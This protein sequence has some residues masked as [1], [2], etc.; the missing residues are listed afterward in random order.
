MQLNFPA[1]LFPREPVFLKCAGDAQKLDNITTPSS[2]RLALSPTNRTQ[3]S[4]TYYTNCDDILSI[5]APFTKQQ[6][7][8][9]RC[10]HIFKL[11]RIPK[12]GSSTMF[13]L[14][15]SLSNGGCQIHRQEG[16]T[17]I[18]ANGIEKYT[19]NLRNPWNRFIS[20]FFYQGHA[21]LFG[22]RSP[23]KIDRILACSQ[24]SFDKRTHTCPT[25]TTGSV[26]I[27]DILE[28]F[29]SN[30]ADTKRQNV[31]SKMWCGQPAYSNERVRCSMYT[32]KRNVCQQLEYAYIVEAPI[33]SLISLQLNF[34]ID[35]V[36]KIQLGIVNSSC[37]L[38]SQF[39]L[40]R[41]N[42]N[43]ELYSLK[44]TLLDKHA[45]L[46]GVFSQKNTYDIELY[47]F[48][49]KVFCSNLI[50]IA[51]VHGLRERVIDTIGTSDGFNILRK[52]C[53]GMLGNTQVDPCYAFISKKANLSV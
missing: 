52:H 10:K 36:D 39:I 27:S 43:Q 44:K 37:R 15:K 1:P 19:A 42:T 6:P 11:L 9:Q 35:K 51:S 16:H 5:V 4:A 23:C 48:M 31:M 24:T 45:W 14:I 25:G 28:C 46:E 12:G 50:A 13:S 29:T 21:G 49:I 7:E 38:K 26:Q 33:A 18:N 32:L 3:T 17:P 47:D 8:R 20:S 22:H 30:L 41:T 34:Q 40:D 2:T 53:A